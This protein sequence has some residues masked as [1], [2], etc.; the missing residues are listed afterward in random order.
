M[1]TN[2]HEWLMGVLKVLNALKRWGLSRVSRL[3][4]SSALS[5]QLFLTHYSSLITHNSPQAPWLKGVKR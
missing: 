4:N 2:L 5:D 1:N 3:I